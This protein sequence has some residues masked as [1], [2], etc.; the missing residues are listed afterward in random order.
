MGQ[1]KN[2]PSDAGAPKPAGSSGL[3]GAVRVFSVR[4]NSRGLSIPRPDHQMWPAPGSSADVADPDIADSWRPSA[5]GTPCAGKQV[6][7][8][9][10]SRQWVSAGNHKEMQILLYIYEE[11]CKSK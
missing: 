9:G 6:L 7:P 4:P 11:P 2:V 10:V 8:K 1:T 3:N 5:S